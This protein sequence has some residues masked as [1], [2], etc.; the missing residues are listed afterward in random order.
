MNFGAM[1]LP[2]S[3]RKHLL[4]FRRLHPALKIAGLLMATALIFFAWVPGLEWWTTPQVFVTKG[5]AREV[6]PLTEMAALFAIGLAV[7]IAY[8]I[9]RNRRSR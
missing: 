9:D 5:M 6:S 2:R 1:R 4:Q 3:I 7:Y 8:V